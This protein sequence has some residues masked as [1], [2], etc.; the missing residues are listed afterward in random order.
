M[1]VRQMGLVWEH[2]RAEGKLLLIALALADWCDDEGYCYPSFRQLARKARC[3]R[4]TAIRGVQQLLEW[5]EVERLEQP[6]AETM[7]LSRARFLRWQKTN[8]YRIVLARQLV[9][10]SPPPGL[11]A[12]GT[13]PP[14]LAA[15]SRTMPSAKHRQVVAKPAKQVVANS[16]LSRSVSSTPSGNTKAS[17]AS[18]ADVPVEISAPVENRATFA[19]LKLLVHE[20]LD[21]DGFDSIA[22]LSDAAKE[23]LAS[24]RMTFDPQALARAIASVL[25]SRGYDRRTSRRA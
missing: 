24:R 20:A 23:L 10:G 9:A 1:S 15:G 5:G 22:E 4:S 7:N 6:H 18:A 3:D 19:Q 21:H 2:S 17:G 16:A 14:P 8:G 13:T 12:G 11:V 25:L